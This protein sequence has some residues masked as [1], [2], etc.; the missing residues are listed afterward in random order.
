M[1][2]SCEKN[3]VA[4]SLKEKQVE[5]SFQQFAI[6]SG[7]VSFNTKASTSDIEKFMTAIDFSNSRLSNDL[8][9]DEISLT[10]KEN[11]YIYLIPFNNE[12]NKFH[13][14]EFSKEMEYRKDFI[15]SYTGNANSGLIVTVLSE[16]S[17]TTVSIAPEGTIS[18]LITENIEGVE[19]GRTAAKFC[20]REGTE[21]FS[22]CYK[23]EVD[24]FC[25]GVIGCL[26]L[27]H[28]GSH[29]VIASACSC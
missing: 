2:F 15:Y 4:N 16:N 26:A 22:D 9:L 10:E 23:R 8:N 18:S 12:S 6:Q 1:L 7:V 5:T 13:A 19:N 14:Y 21:G 25:D 29:L 11:S 24:E 20:Q 3:E 17:K 27:L 28:W